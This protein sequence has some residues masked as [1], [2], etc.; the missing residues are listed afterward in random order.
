MKLIYGTGNPGK[1]RYMKDCL[2]GLDIQLLPLPESD[3]NSEPTEET[4]C[5]PMENARQKAAFYYRR[6]KQ[7]VFS[8]DSGLYI[9][10]LSDAEQPGVHVRRVNGQQLSD[11]QM[12][13]YYA[14]I[15]RRL[16]GRCPARYRNAI[17]LILDE[18]RCYEYDGEDIGGEWF[19]LV[20]QPVEQR[21]A[22]FPLDPISV[23]MNT[24]KYYA[25]DS[26]PGQ[27]DTAREGLRRFFGRIL[28]EVKMTERLYDADAYVREFDSMVLSCDEEVDTGDGKRPRYRVV[29]ERTAFFP[30]GGGQPA[31]HGR[32]GEAE[33]TDVQEEEGRVIHFTDR[34]LASGNYV[35][36]TI[37]WNRRF[38]HM[39]QH[40]GEHVF[41]GIVHGLYGYDNIG[42]HM[43]KDFVT[44]DFSGMLDEEQISRAE[45]LANEVI[46]SDREIFTSYPTDQELAA[47]DYRSKKAIQGAVRIVSIPGADVCA[48]CGTHVR[49]T[50]EIGPVKVTSSEHYKSGIRLTLEIG[51]LALADYDRKH[52][53]VKSISA[54]LSVKPEETGEAVARQQELI[55]ELKAANV[56]LKQKL[57][58]G[59]AAQVKEGTKKAVLFE[60]DLNGVE[61]RKL[62]DMLAR[63]ADLAAVFSGSESDGYKYVICSQ[64][65]D[66]AALGKEFNRELN[67]RGGGR[68]PMIQGSVQASEQA[69]RDFLAG[70]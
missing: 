20:D 5:T 51:W 48:C 57:L 69:V 10:G 56:A 19:W 54:L 6:L 45:R 14:G 39:Q 40:S 27:E 55:Q 2:E 38:L 44:V 17:C 34:P 3:K 9:K 42:F 61:I 36:G 64:K 66:V 60:E 23:D 11:E 4:G 7:P 21:E 47:L 28:G 53:N 67:G 37:D 70:Y 13:E 15:A 26:D 62:A 16:G 50:G 35:H 65:R 31:D 12:T 29:L 33:V 59:L 52:R 25:E 18:N 30:E 68:N 32:L 1:I 63:K 58:E 22:G 46:L 49:R 8:C 41:S 24:G 43:G